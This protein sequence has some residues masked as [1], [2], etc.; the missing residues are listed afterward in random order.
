MYKEVD[1][2]K[3]EIERRQKEAE[4]KDRIIYEEKKYTGIPVPTKKKENRDNL[5][6]NIEN[7]LDE[8]EKGWVRQLFLELDKNKSKFLDRDE[9]K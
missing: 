8:W 2:V 3:K 9:L 5:G 1:H 7:K 4:E 6:R